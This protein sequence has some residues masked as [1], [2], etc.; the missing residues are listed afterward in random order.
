MNSL[1]TL[2]IFIV[3]LFMY[4]HIAN[5]F[6]KGDELEIYET[7]FTTTSHL[8][9]VCELKQPVL[10]NIEDILPKLFSNITPESIARYSGHTVNIKD[11]NDYYNEDIQSVDSVLLPFHTTIKFLETD[12]QSHLFSENNQDF[13]DESGILK[14]IK[15]VD[16]ILKP[17]F[18]VNSR[19]DLLFGSCNTVT[20]LRYHTDSRQFLCVSTGKV[21]VKMTSWKS[22]KYLHKQKDYENYEF[23]SP[24][25]PYQP[26]SDFISDLERTNFIEFDVNAGYML[27]IPPYWWYSISYLNDPSTYICSITYNTFV[28][29]LS[30]SW[31]LSMYFLQ[32]QNIT[33]KTSKQL[34]ESGVIN[35]QEDVKEIVKTEEVTT[36]PISELEENTDEVQ[37]IAVEQTQ[38]VQEEIADIIDISA[39]LTQIKVLPEKEKENIEYS[40][41]NI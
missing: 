5:Q 19:Y 27:Y 12:K 33:K 11:T 39:N 30:N 4:I 13:L 6:K 14:K 34:Q 36:T 35:V 21:R 9:D 40:I 7:D 31:D 29:T 16:N 1:T 10:M 2:C 24:V 25:H 3:I 20:P 17:S 28:N 38:E 23:W 32:Q 18:T 22:S 8:D 26:N 41:S 15:G 37:E